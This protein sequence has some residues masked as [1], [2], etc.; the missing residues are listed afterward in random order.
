MVFI[1]LVLDKVTAK[2][3]LP[4]SLNHQDF[5]CD[6]GALYNGFNR[7]VM[8]VCQQI[9]QICWFLAVTDTCP[10]GSDSCL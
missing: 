4:G 7:F 3:K 5:W 9:W 1:S 2:E 10:F 8:S 6:F